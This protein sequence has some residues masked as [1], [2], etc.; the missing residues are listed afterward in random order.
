MS[1]RVKIALVSLAG[2]LMPVL[3]IFFQT[4]I[5]IILITSL[6]SA[7]IL[8]FVIFKLLSPL[9]SLIQ[10]AETLSSGNLNFRVDVRSHD[11]LEK[12]GEAFNKLAETIKSS[13]ERLEQDK[14]IISAERNKLS[15]VLSSVIDGIIA[16]DLGRRVVLSNKTAQYLT[17]YTEEEMQGQPVDAL[18]HLFNNQEEV[19][20][21]TYCQID[22]TGSA[23]VRVFESLTLIGKEGRKVKVSLTT[24]PILGNLTANLGCLLILHD[25][26]HESELE[27]MKLD[28]VSMAS[29]ELKTP[30]TNIMGYLSVYLD[31]NRP[32]LT[33]DQAGLLDRCLVSTKQLQTLV[34]NL[35]SVNKIEKEQMS[36]AVEPIDLNNVFA[37]T[38]ED[39]QNQAK[40]KNITLNF[41]KN[42][43]LPKVL[44]DSMRLTEVINNLVANAINY[45]EANGKVSVFTQSSPNEVVVTVEDTGVG[46][47]QEAIPHLFNK[48]FRVSNSMQKASKGTGLGLY[49]S[50][51]IIQK[52]NGKIWVESEVGK[53]SKFHFSLPIARKDS[54]SLN[55][56]KFVSEAIQ[57]G[58]LNY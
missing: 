48:F 7:V 55:Q 47:P 44:A 6:I 41:V 20:A 15:S 17:G 37:K 24:S 45:T 19:S 49:I 39:L 29:H 21:K 1:V 40:L 25:M 30:L 12:L 51:S 31:E 36:V 33:K 52:L 42:E 56:N 2:I 54:S 32:T 58:A 23:A 50:K 43:A 16:V 9:S 38:I 53:G 57:A 34:E 14:D 11:E 35:L 5:L 8:V 22:L 10:G 13:V 18:L 3:A 46:I 26:T 4:S 27:Q 28:F